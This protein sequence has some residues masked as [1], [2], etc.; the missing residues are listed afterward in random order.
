MKLKMKKLITICVVVTM[1]LAVSCTAQ[2]SWETFVIRGSASV[3]PNQTAPDSTTGWTL[4]DVSSGGEKAGWAT[5]S[6]NGETIG[7]IQSLSITR[8]VP[9][10][11]DTTFD[12]NGDSIGKKF[13][14]MKIKDGKRVQVQ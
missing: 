14:K 4:F 5:N 1:V 2:A 11:G 10:T 7:D 8:Y 3:T 6:M 13:S 12:E 9:A